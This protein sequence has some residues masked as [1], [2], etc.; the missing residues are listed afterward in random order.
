VNPRRPT[1]HQNSTGK[2]A[3]AEIKPEKVGP[4][5]VPKESDRHKS[6]L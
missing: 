5:I 1:V 6:M 3:L 4:A 2:N